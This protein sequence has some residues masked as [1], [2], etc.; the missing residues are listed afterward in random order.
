MTMMLNRKHIEELVEAQTEHTLGRLKRGET[1]PERVEAALRDLTAWFHHKFG[2]GSSGLMRA[3]PEGNRF[4]TFIADADAAL[5]ATTQEL[6]DSMPDI[7]REAVDRL[8]DG[9]MDKRMFAQRRAVLDVFAVVRIVAADPYTLDKVH[10]AATVF[11]LK[12]D[13]ADDTANT[14]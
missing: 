9:Y 1:T 6:L 5:H 14:L 8:T 7:L 12:D 4:V 10:N 3:T 13:E 2:E 11:R